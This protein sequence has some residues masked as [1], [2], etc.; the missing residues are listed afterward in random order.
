MSAEQ[1]NFLKIARIVL[2]IFPKYLRK[3][4]KRQW[5]ENY[6]DEKWCSG[7]ESDFLYNKL[8]E[9]VKNN[10]GRKAELE[11]LK[12]GNDQ[13][14]DTTTLVFAILDTGLHLVEPVRPGE[15]SPP[16]RISEQMFTLRKIR[17][18]VFGH[19]ESMSCPFAKLHETVSYI[20]SSANSIFNQEGMKEIDE[21]ANSRIETE[22]IDQLNRQLKKEKS[23][24]EELEL[25]FAGVSK[26]L[27]A[28]V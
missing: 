16:L 26:F 24:N 18:D 15:W 14:W 2:A 23:R 9:K 10:K 27:I 4:L 20:K 17:N 1:E 28:Q 6:P 11:R 21:I 12:N 3:L 19:L 22:A 13:N 5:D 25:Y 8:T 7:K